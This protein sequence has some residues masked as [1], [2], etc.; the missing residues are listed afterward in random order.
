[1]NTPRDWGK[2]TGL[3]ATFTL[4]GGALLLAISGG[5]EQR[6]LP[7]NSANTA[8]PAQ[9]EGGSGATNKR[10]WAG[11]YAKLPLTFEENQGQSTREVR[12][13][14]H[15]TGYELF[16]TSQEAVLALRDHV[17]LDLSP[18]H[19]FATILAL[20]KARLA[21]QAHQLTAIRL[22]FEGAN[23]DPQILGM[24]EMP[25]KVNYFFGN[26]PK[27]WHTGIP[28]Y[29]RV[30]YAGL[31]PGVDLVFY[32]NQRHLE[33]DFVVAPGADPKVIQLRVQGAGKL[34]VNANGDLLLNAGKGK[35]ELQKP[36][37]YQ[38]ANG[39]RREIAGRYEILAN[40]RVGFVV[41]EYDR[42]KPLIL[43]PVLNYSTYLG[44]SSDDDSSAI[45]VD[46]NK[47][48]IV[49]GTTFSADFPS[50]AS[51]NGFQKEP[52]AANVGGA[53]A[54]FVTELDPTGTQLKYSSYL[55]GSTPF[56]FAF[57]V[58]VDATGMIY[59][60]GTT[61]STDFPTGS[62]VSGLKPTSPANVNGTSFIT[63]LDPTASGASSLLYSSYLGGTDGT[64]PIGDIGLGIAADRTQNGVVYITGYTDSTAGLVTDTA[65]FPVV[66]GF[67][68]TLGSPSG[69][70]FLSKID[71][72]V[73]GTG[74]LLYSTYFGGNAVNFN[75]TSLVADF[76]GGAAVDSTSNVY[77]A[78]VTFSTDLATT[79]NAVQ[80]SYP[81]GNSTNTA[82]VARVDTTQT[83]A[84]SLGYLSYLGGA[85]IDFGDAIALGP[86]NVAYVTGKTSSLNF[87]TTTGAFSTTGNASGPAFVALIDTHAPAPVPPATQNSPVYS[88]FLGGSGG[89][90][91]L[92]IRVDANG[93]AYVAGG[94]SSPDFPIIAG[95]IQPT[96]ATS[97]G[98]DGFISELN[99]GGN[100][101]ADLLYSTY[102]G[103]SGSASGNDGIE[104]IA[105]DSSNNVYVTGQTFSATGAFPVF[106]NP[107]ALQAV[108]KGTS[109][110][111]VAK[112]T[113]IPT[114]S[115]A[116]T[117]INFGLQPVG[118]T[119]VAQ[120]VT[121]TNNTSDP[122]P[123][124][125]SDLAFSG[126]N[127]ADFAS[128]S[129]TC[130]TSIA[131]GASCTV[132]VTFTP[133]VAAAES[134]T[135]VIT[136]TITNGGVSSSQSFN[137]SLAGT[138]S[139]TA[140][141]VGL[142]P[143]SLNFGGQMLT[144]TSAAQAVTLTNTGN[145]PL[146]INSIATSGDFAATNTG[147][148]ACPIG[149]ATLAAAANCSINVTFAPTALA[150]R[151]GTLTI[152][153]NA[154]G[155]PHVI[156][157]TGSGFD[158]TVTATT[159][160]AGKS[161]LVFNAT[162]TPLGGFNQAV[163]F[164]CTGAPAGSTC[165]V[166]TPVT[167]ADGATPQPVQVTLTRNSSGLFASPHSLR[168]P[169][170]SLWQIVPLLLA[171]LL[172]FLL[173]KVRG[174]RARLGLVTATVVLIGL[175]GCSGP[176]HIVP[177][178]SGN[179]TITGMSTGAAGNVSH[180]AQVAVTLN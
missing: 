42:S 39:E 73:S 41:G 96:L 88:T 130:G 153:D 59:V 90:N 15:G 32:G 98:G 85:G 97:A 43:D 33:Y 167:A 81:A 149:P 108:L 76:G 68:T 127:A 142:S 62:V 49:A 164:T 27:K 178:L 45:A 128:P 123:F 26:D 110:G 134:A 75:G 112:L 58:D 144:T 94:T 12:Y 23:P 170:L 174:H 30:K 157:L 78:G 180:S 100:G 65:N 84:A 36:V 3:L 16:L 152:T 141:G 117:S 145:G 166:A 159:P 5:S 99:P 34:R 162:M 66:G 101:T 25:G 135:L 64:Q 61:V 129:N 109:D 121:L 82:F 119:S 19:R 53:S 21:R 37:I 140:P 158:F 51:V 133:A 4:I 67:Q 91:G 80:P 156:Q 165:T 77:V 86:N 92:G 79:A 11:T 137:V 55:S 175:A 83:G 179:L 105:L 154:G 6:G 63:K 132:G 28:A 151:T 176:K 113:L 93:N 168:T 172:L 139:A 124:A 136:V 107:G 160:Q 106:P 71:T 143:T 24:D 114:L 126:S 60:T 87:P 171:L 89:D 9:R 102:F 29:T 38:Q 169:P 54:A 1:M 111:F 7:V 69:N 150:S 14:S 147:A 161:P 122:I 131:A 22:G 72:T 125:N 155:S 31:Y 48:V 52:V 173:P 35:I 40:H 70:A 10:E 56:E 46:A 13:L 57:S 95:A 115:V 18:R 47:N 17:R 44:G 50:P 2:M 104:G 148:G 177:P 116:P 163:A 138:G 120:T 20:R 8:A 146:T 118:A 103:G 74:S